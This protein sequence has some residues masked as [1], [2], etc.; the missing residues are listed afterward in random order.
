MALD[1]GYVYHTKRHFTSDGYLNILEVLVDGDVYDLFIREMTRRYMQ[2]MDRNFIY[3]FT[4]LKYFIKPQ[5]NEVFCSQLM[6][7][8]LKACGLY[9]GKIPTIEF[10]PHMVYEFVQSIKLSESSKSYLKDTYL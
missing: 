4:P 6:M 7:E 8:G 9:K 3:R 1:P 10:T 5:D 2:K